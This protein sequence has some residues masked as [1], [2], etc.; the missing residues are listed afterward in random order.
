MNE[1][2]IGLQQEGQALQKVVQLAKSVAIA[3]FNH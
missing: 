3:Q 2:N 1:E